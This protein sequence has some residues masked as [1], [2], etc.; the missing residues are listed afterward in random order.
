LATSSP[1]EALD[2][3]RKG[4][5]FDIAILDMQMPEMDGLQL[6]RKIRGLGNTAEILPL[7]ML[8]SQGYRGSDKE[9][10]EFAAF[11]TKPIKPSLLFNTLVSIFTGQA[12]Q[13]Q[14]RRK[15]EENQFDSQMGKKHPLRILLAEDNGTNQ[16]VALRILERIGYTAEVVENGNAVLAAFKGQMYDVVLMDIQMPEM[17]GLEATRQLRQDLDDGHQPYIIAMTA[18]AMQGDREACLLAGMDDYISKP[19]RVEALVRALNQI[20]SLKRDQM[21]G[22]SSKEQ[23]PIRQ[24]ED[25]Q[26]SPDLS[27]SKLDQTALRDLYIVLGEDFSYLAKLIDSFI[28]DAPKMLIDL[29]KAVDENNSKEVQRLAHSLKSNGNDFGATQ[30]A[31]LCKELEGKGKAEQLEGARELYKEILA[32][33]KSVETS[34]L[35]IRQKEWQGN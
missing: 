27:S 9:I 26:I 13:V 32:E 30:L 1:L 21:A 17:D 23:V 35:D 18:N 25:S 2:W 20:H 6:A 29:E 11:L 12:T 24:K 3:I 15:A 4:K 7:V 28:E 14:P 34:L 19:I 33:F 10:K 5:S 16:I 22:P 8:T 31:S